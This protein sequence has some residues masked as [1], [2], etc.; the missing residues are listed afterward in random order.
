MTTLRKRLESVSKEVQANWPFYSN[1]FDE[2]LKDYSSSLAFTAGKSNEEV[3]IALKTVGEIRAKIQEST[4]NYT[5][6]PASTIK[7]LQSITRIKHD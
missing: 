5:P 6:P 2:F 1:M 3:G 7:K 4:I